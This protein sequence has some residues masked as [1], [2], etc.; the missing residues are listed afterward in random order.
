M[1]DPRFVEPSPY[2]VDKGNLIGKDPSRISKS[3]LADLGHHKSYPKTIRAY[4]LECCLGQE[5]E[6]RKC[7]CYECPLWPF[8]MGR[9]PF[10][11]R[12]K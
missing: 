3:D 2:A 10:D 1:R 9:N 11:A 6:V 7:V 12:A 5:S 4:C 8:R